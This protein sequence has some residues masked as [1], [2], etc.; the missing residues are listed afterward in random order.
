MGP[1]EVAM[2]PERKDRERA[3]REG[4]KCMILLGERGDGPED[5]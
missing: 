1:I 3:R 2:E 5:R 4:D